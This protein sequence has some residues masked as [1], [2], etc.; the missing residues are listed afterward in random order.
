D[1]V[2]A[3]GRAGV[4]TAAIHLGDD[5]PGLRARAN[6][7]EHREHKK[8]DARTKPRAKF[9]GEQDIL[10]GTTLSAMQNSKSSKQCPEG[11][12]PG[13][14]DLSVKAVVYHS[15]ISTSVKILCGFKTPRAAR[16]TNPVPSR[17]PVRSG[18]F[19]VKPPSLSK[20]HQLQ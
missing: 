10:L 8:G 3:P 9:D 16:A 20:S 5:Q 4:P 19:L 12:F 17:S 14:S 6:G 2:I 15:V 11:G 13:Q 18:L 1:E 7:E